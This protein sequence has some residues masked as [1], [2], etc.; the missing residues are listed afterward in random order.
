MFGLKFFLKVL[1]NPFANYFKSTYTLINL[2]IKNP[3]LKLYSKAHISNSQFGKYNHI[4]PNAQVYTSSFGDFSY[5]GAESYIYD[6]RIGKFT[7]IGPYVKIGLGE[8]PSQDFISIHPVFYSLAAQTGITFADNQYFKE[9][10]VTNVGNDVWIGAGAIIRA[11]VTI[12]DGVIV[13]AGAVVTKD[14]P[15]FAIVG[16]IPARI[17]KYRFEQE[18][19]TKLLNLKWWD[20]DIALLKTYFKEMHH[21]Q[22]IDLLFR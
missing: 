16:G 20:K 7:C 10:S 19:I 14:V 6:V 3:T 12:G 17:I 22:N 4:A 13:A 11:G 5:V 21:I 15:P 18:D 9:F 1:L 2:K 8:H